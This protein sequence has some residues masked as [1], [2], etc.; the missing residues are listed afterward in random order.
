MGCEVVEEE[1]EDEEDEDEVLV[2][3]R[4]ESVDDWDS[5]IDEDVEDASSC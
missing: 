1:D 2:S 4:V 5:V 3:V